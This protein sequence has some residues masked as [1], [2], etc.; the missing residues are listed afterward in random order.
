[1][2]ISVLNWTACIPDLNPTETLWCT[3]VRALYE[4]FRQ[5]NNL[6]VLKE[7]IETVWD[8]IDKV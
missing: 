6:A 3:L 4:D 5:F 8:K 2:V 7:A 1:M